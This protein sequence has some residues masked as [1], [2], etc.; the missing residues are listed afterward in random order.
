MAVTTVG[1]PGMQ[2]ESRV[3]VV[4]T[5]GV[6][7]TIARETTCVDEEEVAMAARVASSASE[8]RRLEKAC[9]ALTAISISGPSPVAAMAVSS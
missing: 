5:L 4:A 2:T 9:K 3:S 1:A 6:D 7:R 8:A